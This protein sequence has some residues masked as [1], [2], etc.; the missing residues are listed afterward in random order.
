M[1]TVEFATVF[2]NDWWSVP[3]PAHFG[4]LVSVRSLVVRDTF[5]E[6]I[7]IEPTEQAAAGRSTAPWRMFR[8]SD[9]ELAAGAGPAP[10]V[11]LL[12]PVIAGA[13]EG[14]ALEDVL[15]LRDEMANLAWAV[16]RVVEG[17]DGRPRNRSIEY[18]TRL[19]AAPT[20]EIAS[21]AE[22][23]LR[24]ADERARALDPAGPRA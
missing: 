23:V 7:L 21:P 13:L 16:E 22:L 9:A 2:G 19:T 4:S 18:G 14:D 3:V 1:L 20:P 5:G 24:A 12:V 8:Q 11:L 15:L 6:S 17:A 10:G